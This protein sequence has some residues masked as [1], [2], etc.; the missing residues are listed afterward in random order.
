[1]VFF[2]CS[3]KKV[4]NKNIIFEKELMMKKISLLMLPLILS[5]CF[6]KPKPPV[7]KKITREEWSKPKR[8]QVF[9]APLL[10]NPCAVNVPVTRE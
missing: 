5:G 4:Y 8:E 10:E 1:M 7:I 3:K 9:D 2:L 6:E